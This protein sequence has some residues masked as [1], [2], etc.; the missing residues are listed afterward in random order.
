MVPVR[1]I[2]NAVILGGGLAGLSAAIRCKEMGVENV[3]VLERE[4]RHGGLAI[5]LQ[6]EGMT[7]DLGPHRFYTEIPEVE[8]FYREIAGPSMTT[9]RRSSSM[10]LDDKFLQYPLRIRDLIAGPGPARLAVFGAS[11]L[12]SHLRQMSQSDREE[13]FEKYMTS[14]FGKALYD[15]L[16]GP[17]TAKV[18]KTDPSQLD[19][20][21]ART[22]V[23]AGSLTKMI[24]GMF[25]K[26]K[27][28]Q[29]TALKEFHYIKGGAQSLVNLLVEHAHVLG[30]KL[31]TR[32]DV[33]DFEL[34]AD[35]SIASVIAE[36]DGERKAFPADIV[37]STIPFPHLFKKVYQ[38]LP[39]PGEVIRQVDTLRYLDLIFVYVIVR[40]DS[41]RGDQWIYF[42]DPKYL[43][44]RASESKAFDPEMGTQG[45]SML[46]VEVTHHQGDRF[47]ETPDDEIAGQ[48]L[49]QLTATGIFARE[50]VS[51]TYVHRLPFA[52][53]LYDL[54]YSQRL[55]AALKEMSRVSNLVTTGRQGLFSFNNM[56]HSIFMGMKAAECCLES[57]QPAERWLA[58]HHKFRSFRIVD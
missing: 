4:A 2:R 36:H 12:R 19:A 44:N 8:N 21:A 26:E 1:D 43:F 53:P 10:F 18:W 34:S 50:E 29:Q 30:A 27:K 24:R 3:V 46:C 5:S 40:R 45:R 9:V 16:I 32:H 7:S 52:Y 56:D 58:E 28:G 23:S 54:H 11:W 42:T 41:I 48:V 6:Y 14:A 47:A 38:T 25:I 13:S 33:V 39:M 49:D 17:Y 31:L 20:D 35:G 37:I 55:E 57:E 51:A 15:Y 22:R